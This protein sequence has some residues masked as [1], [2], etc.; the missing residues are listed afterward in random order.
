MTKVSRNEIFVKAERGGDWLDDFVRI[1]SEMKDEPTSI[2]EILGAINNK[3][4]ETIDSVMEKYREQAGLNA[5]SGSEQMHVKTASTTPLSVR[6]AALQGT[7]SAVSIIQKDPSVEKAIDSL[8]KHSGGTKSTHAIINYLRNVLGK[9]LVSY[10]DKD[11][12]KYIEDRKKAFRHEEPVED[13]ADV[14]MVGLEDDK[15]LYGDGVADY[16]QH[17]QPGE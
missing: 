8:C 13:M 12:I 6:H 3:R 10:T 9:E 4:S 16:V 2:D 11:L 1:Y 17:G 7:P 15:D 5:L 14:G